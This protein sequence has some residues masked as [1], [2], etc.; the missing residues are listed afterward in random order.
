M[1]GISILGIKPQDYTDFHQKTFFSKEHSICFSFSTV[2][3]FSKKKKC[4][5]NL[6]KS[7]GYKRS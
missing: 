7:R 3:L 5:V 1:K 4:C 2:F 6:V